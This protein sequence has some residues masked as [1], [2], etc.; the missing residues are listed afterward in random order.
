MAGLVVLLGAIG[1]SADESDDG[2]SEPTP[3]LS[4]P[5]G[6]ARTSGVPTTPAL[7]DQVTLGRDG[8]AGFALGAPAADVEA[9]L[10]ELLGPA[11]T[12]DE[13]CQG[14]SDRSVGW[15]SG[16]TVYFAADQLSGWWLR[17]VADDAPVVVETER[18]ITAGDSVE[19]LLA[20]EPDDFQWVPDSTLG[21][22]FYV[23]TG[24]PYLGGVATGEEPTDTIESL[25][26]G[27]GC[28]SR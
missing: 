10:G 8:L 23:G 22:E 14:G 5:E 7:P 2:A 26:A 16:L 11:E 28:V 1:C 12:S 24:F 4:V 20:A 17:D 13:A 15:T 9:L 6:I 27:D 19:A 3:T 25:W 18:G 21:T